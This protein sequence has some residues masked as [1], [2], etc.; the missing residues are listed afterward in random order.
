MNAH[1]GPSKALLGFSGG[2]ESGPGDASGQGLTGGN[3]Q[4]KGGIGLA[5]KYQE[6]SKDSSHGF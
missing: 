1:S 2:H 6:Q 5:G 3:A 4:V